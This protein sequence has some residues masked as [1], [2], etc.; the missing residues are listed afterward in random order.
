MQ[1]QMA[2]ISTALSTIASPMRGPSPSDLSGRWRLSRPRTRSGPTA[3]QARGPQGIL[4]ILV[5][6]TRCWPGHIPAASR[7]GGQGQPG[8]LQDPARTLQVCLLDP[9]AFKPISSL[10]AMP[11]KALIP[12]VQAG[13]NVVQYQAPRR[14]LN[15]QPHRRQ[16]V[17]HGLQYISAWCKAGRV[18]TS[19]W[20]PV[21]LA[22]PIPLADQR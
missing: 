16:L 5:N 6:C 21:E 14:M 1:T 7:D 9:A 12:A 10:E 22:M 15:C 18:G 20:I 13:G 4:H 17:W 19:Q 8:C 2:W 3:W 11:H